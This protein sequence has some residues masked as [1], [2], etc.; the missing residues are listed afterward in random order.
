MYPKTRFT[1]DFLARLYCAHRVLQALTHPAR[2]EVLMLLDQNGPMEVHQVADHLEVDRSAISHHLR[3]LLRAG[4]VHR[5]Q[6]GVFRI[7]SIN[8]ERM[9]Q[10][11]EGVVALRPLT[12][13]GQ[14][15][16]W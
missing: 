3:S 11:A 16:Q 1:E 2:L 9:V 10:L 13:G 5:E 6:R 8:T 14:A 7:Y 15:T 4:C 12:Q